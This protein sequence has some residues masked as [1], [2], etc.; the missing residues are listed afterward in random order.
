MLNLQKTHP[1]TQPIAFNEN[2]KTV[3]LRKLIRKKNFYG[4]TVNSR[5]TENTCCHEEL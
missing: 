1:E 2:P 3:I 4:S 5:R